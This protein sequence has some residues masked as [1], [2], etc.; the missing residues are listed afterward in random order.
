[1]ITNDIIGKYVDLRSATVEDAE[2]ALNIRHTPKAMKFMPSLN[3]TVEQQ[4]SWIEKQRITEGDY[5]FIVFNK[6]NERIGV[7]S[8]YDIHDNQ[9]E[10]GRWVMQGGAFES[11]ESKL[12][13][14]QF[15]FNVLKLKKLV[16]YIYPDN[17]STLKASQLFGCKLNK[18][19]HDE[20]RNLDFKNLILQPEDFK[21]AEAQIIVILYNC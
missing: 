7:I 13:I 4:K 17:V 15:S 1:M 2:F 6:N 16:E 12:L 8:V 10:I 21:R 20:E 5:F 14:T 19:I 9:G 18:I 11:I 3:I